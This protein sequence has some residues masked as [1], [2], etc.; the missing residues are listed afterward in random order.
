MQFSA[1]LDSAVDTAYAKTNVLSGQWF[2]VPDAGR[3]YDATITL[4]SP[5]TVQHI[6]VATNEPESLNTGVSIGEIVTYS[7]VLTVPDDGALTD[8]VLTLDLESGFSFVDL[9]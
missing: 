9:V 7:V 3:L 1:R 2:S 4:S 8:A 5:S 6:F